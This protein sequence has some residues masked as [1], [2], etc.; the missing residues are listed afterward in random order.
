ML[1]GRDPVCQRRAP[2]RTLNEVSRNRLSRQDH[3]KDEPS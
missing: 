1:A 2:A 3:R